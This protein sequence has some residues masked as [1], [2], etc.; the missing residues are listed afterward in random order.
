MKIVFD[1]NMNT[2]TIRPVFFLQRWIAQ[3]IFKSTRPV[4]LKEF[5]KV[6]V[7]SE[8]KSNQ[9]YYGIYIKKGLFGITL[10]EFR[11][12]EIAQAISEAI[13]KLG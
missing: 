1:A 12:K 5:P 2:I 3:Y 13:N 6:N 9:S 10:L 11:N 7:S 4:Y 8:F